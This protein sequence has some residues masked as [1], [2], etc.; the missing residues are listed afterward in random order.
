MEQP[1]PFTLLIEPV[2][3]LERMLHKPR[4]YSCKEILG[5][6]EE[7]HLRE[8]DQVEVELPLQQEVWQDLQ[9]AWEVQVGLLELTAKVVKFALAN[10]TVKHKVITRSFGSFVVAESNIAEDIIK[11]FI[12][13]IISTEGLEPYCNSTFFLSQLLDLS[14]S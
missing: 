12:V 2:K 11:S 5:R 9:L 3:T 8:E 13:D 10:I 4:L 1:F 7:H 14:T 6:G